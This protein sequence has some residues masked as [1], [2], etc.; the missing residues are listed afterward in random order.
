MGEHILKDVT[1]T[2]KRGEW[3]TLMGESGSGKS[4][5]A[6]AIA[7]LLPSSVL[8]EKGDIFFEN[9][10]TKSFSANEWRKIR[11]KEISFIFQDYYNTF[12]PFIKIGHHCDEVIRSHEAYSKEE[13]KNMIIRAFEDMQLPAERVYNSYPFQLSGGQM[14]RVAIA[15]AIVLRPKLLIADEPTTALDSVTA[16]HVLELISYIKQQMNCAVLFIT[17]DIR[18]A[19]KYSDTIAVMKAGEIVEYGEKDQLLRSPCHPYTK[20][21]FDAAPKLK[22]PTYV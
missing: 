22:R 17:H 21:L 12:T 5:T 13:R 19:K 16:A 7:G 10:N 6:L 9:R 18:H 11:G 1:L 4:M 20:S 3:F 14:Q 2:V 8:M 15:L